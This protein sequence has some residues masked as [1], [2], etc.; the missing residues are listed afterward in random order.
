MNTPRSHKPA[1]VLTV[2]SFAVL[3]AGC[4]KDGPPS[5]SAKGGPGGRSRVMFP[6]EVAPVEVRTMVYS[7][8]A[9]GSVDAF[10][11]AQPFLNPP[12]GLADPQGEI[13]FSFGFHLEAAGS[14]F[15]FFRAPGR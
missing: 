14:G 2:L 3:A 8:G 11:K 6:V 7:V 5:P 15:R 9:V 12:T 4:K 10:E 1:I 13:R